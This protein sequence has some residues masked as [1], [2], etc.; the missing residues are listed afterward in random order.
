MFKKILI[1]NRGEIACRV[2]K[3]ARRMGIK[4]VAVYSEAD[5]ASLHVE[6]A[7]EAVAIGAAP[8]AQSY[9]VI[10]KIIEA[11]KKTGAEAVHP[12]YGFLSERSAFPKA[13]AE[14]GIT[15]IGP[16]PGAI[17]AMGDKI[18]S[19]KAAAAAKVSTVPGH[20][21]IIEDEAE[22]VKIA[23]KIGY[24]VMIKASAGGGGKGMRIAHSDAEVLDGF[25]RARSEAKSSFGDDRVFIEKFIVNP[26]HVEI[27]VLGDKHG[28]VIYLGERECSIQRR[29]Q[30]VIEE[31][32]SPLLDEKTRKAMGEQAVALA[33]A[34]NYDSAGTVE[35]VAGQ[36]RS[37]FF[38]EMNTRLQVE[39]PVTELITGIDLVEQMIRVAAGEKLALQQ[40]D[41]K[42]KGWAVESRVYAE[43]PYRNFL[44]STGRLI[45]YRPP[46]ES[47]EDGITVRNDTGVFE[48]GE[49]SI[50]YD[51][52]IAK[53]CTHAADRATAIAAMGTAL[54]EFYV[55]GIQHNIPF[56]SAIMENERWK[57]GQLSTGFIAEEFQGGFTGNELTP[58][59][60]ARLSAVA[61]MADHV[62]NRRKRLIGGQ[63][64][65][66][67]VQYDSDRVVRLGAKDWLPVSIVTEGERAL[68]L[69]NGAECFV[70]SAWAPGQ[71]VWR[72]EIDGKPVS[73]LLRKILNGYRLSHRGVS[74][75]AHVFSTREA[76]L[77]RLMPEKKAADTSKKLLCPMPGLVVS[78]AVTD[79]QEIKAGEPLAIVEAMK[80]ENIL[81]AERDAVVKKVHVKKG[82]SLAVDAVIME[83]A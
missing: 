82:D 46:K 11:C 38:L 68:T 35:F 76:E 43:D 30:K 69:D 23:R 32:P 80:M 77:A 70:K 19:K 5:A 28:N 1:A 47:S 44:P 14:A 49:I 71:E 3:T 21:G 37:F 81:R 52:M 48:G 50:Y 83:F 74:V 4:T 63:M 8:A 7:D 65:G 55:D 75:D 56:L 31:A 34:V 54:D 20:L 62:E 26:R 45:K 51:P 15:F 78:I 58:E 42:L 57:S 60:K 25:A 67:K 73:V 39:H 24:P 79:G 33:K 40:K 2:I 29:N 41:V 22:A 9:L 66:R 18:E 10:E 72:G 36:D 6:M 12:G 53:L 27:Q 61:V 16:N 17:D 13:L 59:L 64:N